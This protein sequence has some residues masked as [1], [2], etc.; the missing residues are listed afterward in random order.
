MK[1]EIEATRMSSPINNLLLC[2]IEEFSQVDQ[3][4]QLQE[5]VRCETSK[6]AYALGAVGECGSLVICYSSKLITILNVSIVHQCNFVC[7]RYDPFTAIDESN[8]IFSY[9]MGTLR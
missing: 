4:L 5:S 6:T 3:L 9:S 1:Q 7:N 8:I 2:Y